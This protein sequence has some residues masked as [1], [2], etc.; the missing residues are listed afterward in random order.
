MKLFVGNV[1]QLQVVFFV[2]VF[3][4]KFSESSVQFKSGV[5]FVELPILSVSIVAFPSL[6]VLE[7]PLIISHL[8]PEIFFNLFYKVN[9]HVRVFKFISLDLLISLR[10]ARIGIVMFM[11]AFLY[12][13]IITLFEFSISLKFRVVIMIFSVYLSVLYSI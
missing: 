10:V 5:I 7:S 12:T 3:I 4:W 11:Y 6:V 2:K 1:V 9:V 13:L 8:T